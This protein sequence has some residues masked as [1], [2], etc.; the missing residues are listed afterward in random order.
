MVGAAVALF[1][2][3]VA[4]AL[5]VVFT[6]NGDE[7]LAAEEPTP[8][9]TPT[10]TPEADPEPTPEPTPT[11][12]PEPGPPWPLTGLPSE[13]GDDLGRPAVAAKLDNHPRARP[14]TGMGAADVV[15]V[16]LV[17]GLTR[18][19]GVYHS[20]QPDVVGPI[21][22]ARLVDADIVPA[23]DPAFAFS[24]AADQVMPT[25]QGTGM[26]LVVEGHAGY[27]REPTRP[28]PHDLYIE[29][30]QLWAAAEGLPAA[31]VPWAH[32]EEPPEGGEPAQRTTLTYPANGGSYAWE[33]DGEAWLREQGGSPHTDADGEQLSA[34]NVAVLDVDWVGAER[35]P[36]EPLGEGSATFLRDGEA[37]EGTWRKHE[38]DDP[39]ELLD[40]DGEPFALA[41]GAT[42]I[43]LLPTGGTRDLAPGG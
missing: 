8:T 29:T 42:W 13:E 30:D 4:L 10:P 2:A 9:P 22:S 41:P 28:A 40:A 43:E 17:E 23:F 34:A 27:F 7:N 39:Y 26:P 20:Q 31:D 19:I 3:G 38:R 37:H 1:L 6:A 5:V 25:I 14:Q 11:P 18:M 16:E 36:F 12:T 24:G 35:R 33:W 21:R 15:V 32:D